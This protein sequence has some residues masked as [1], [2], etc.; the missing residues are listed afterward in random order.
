M[1]FID[2]IED[3]HKT[4]DYYSQELRKRNYSWGKIFLPHDGGHGDYKTGKTAQEI[5]EG[6]KWEVEVLPA[7]SVDEGIRATRMMLKQTYVD[8]TKCARLV[9][10]WKRYRRSIPKST[11]EPAGPLHDQFSHGADMTRYVAMAAPQMD[12]EL[13]MKLPPL[14]YGKSGVL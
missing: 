10:C 13:Q 3:S 5:L 7:L 9:E 6:L 11:N 14:K 8:R 2:Y 12:N 1:R 4:L